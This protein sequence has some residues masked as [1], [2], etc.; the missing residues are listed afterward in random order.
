MVDAVRRMASG[1][2][3]AGQAGGGREDDKVTDFV[4]LLLLRRTEF[5][6]STR[7]CRCQI[8]YSLARRVSII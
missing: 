7:S 1:A 6:N 2:V 8:S 4:I 5:Q 3:V